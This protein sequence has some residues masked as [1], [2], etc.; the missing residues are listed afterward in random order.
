[1]NESKVWYVPCKEINLFLEFCTPEKQDRRIQYELCLNEVQYSVLLERVLFLLYW[2][3]VKCIY[4]PGD[5]S[6][7][8]F[9]KMCVNGFWD[10]A[11]CLT[12]CQNWIKVFIKNEIFFLFLWSAPVIW[13]HTLADIQYSLLLLLAGAKKCLETIT[14]HCRQPS[15]VLFSLYQFILKSVKLFST[16]QVICRNN[17][18]WSGLEYRSAAGSSTGAFG[19]WCDDEHQCKCSS[20]YSR[21]SE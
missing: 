19:V 7:I 15:I 13:M 6:A 17:Q 14:R 20:V 18:A 21:G 11:S 16:E 3:F 8:L 2:K 10:S 12:Y 5:I 9:W 1:M 4:F